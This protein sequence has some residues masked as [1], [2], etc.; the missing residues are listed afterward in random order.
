MD[1]RADPAP[2]ARLLRQRKKLQRKRPSFRRVESWRYKRVKDSWR[3]ARGIDS[4]T[5]RKKKSGVKSPTSG[6]RSPKAVRSLHP[7]GLKVAKVV[8]ERDLEDFDPKKH[9]IVLDRRLGNRKKLPLYESIQARGFRI[10]NP[11]KFAKEP[12]VEELPEEGL[13]EDEEGD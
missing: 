1:R 8:N 2:P 11:P 13:E 7:C 9:A 6:Y 3:R 10:I 4:K 5:R 12:V